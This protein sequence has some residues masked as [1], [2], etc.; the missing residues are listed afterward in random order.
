MPIRIASVALAAAAMALAGCQDAPGPARPV[1][2]PASSAPAANGVAALDAD[3]ILKRAIDALTAARSYR[4]D[5]Y[6]VQ[7]GKRTGIGLAVSPEGFSASMAVG[8]TQVEL[9]EV[10]GEQYIRSNEGFWI[11]AVGA[12]RGKVMA[13]LIGER[14]VTGAK[15]D[16]SFAQLFSIGSPEQFL[17]PLKELSKGAEKDVD[18]V[19]AIAL[20][21]AAERGSV[22]YVATTGEPYPL[23]MTDGRSSLEFSDFGV[24]AE[25]LAAPAP[26]DVVDLDELAGL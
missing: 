18:G 25:A 12:R 7:Q 21:D 1:A 23:L 13:E 2:A 5:G 19:P 11:D 14:W 9:L 8:D 10:A 15:K 26:D 16:E 6:L 22:L 3:K 24:P 4:V 17:E 20:H